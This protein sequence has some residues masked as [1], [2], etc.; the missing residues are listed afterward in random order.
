MAQPVQIPLVNGMTLTPRHVQEPLSSAYAGEGT[1]EMAR[2]RQL[3]SLAE[4]E[5]ASTLVLAAPR[6]SKAQLLSWARRMMCEIY[7]SRKVKSADL[8]QECV[9]LR[10]FLREA[11]SQMFGVS[12]IVD[13]TLSGLSEACLQFPENPDIELFSMWI[14]PCGVP[15]LPVK[16]TAAIPAA[17][18]YG[19][20]VL[21]IFLHTRKLLRNFLVHPFY[22]RSRCRRRRTPAVRVLSA[23]EENFSLYLFSASDAKRVIHLALD[24]FFDF[25]AALRDAAGDALRRRAYDSD[26]ESAVAVLCERSARDG[27][28]PSSSI[29]MPVLH[30]FMKYLYQTVVEFCAATPGR[31]FATAAG[32]LL[33]SSLSLYLDTWEEF[34]E[35]LH[36]E[37]QGCL[38]SRGAV[39][40]MEVS[41]FLTSW[42]SNA[43]T[44][45]DGDSTETPLHIMRKRNNN[46]P[47]GPV[48]PSRRGRSRRSDSV[49]S[50]G[51][52]T[53]PVRHGLFLSGPG[54]R[55]EQEETEGASHAAMC[56]ESQPLHAKGWESPV[57]SRRPTSSPERGSEGDTDGVNGAALEMS[58]PAGAS[59]PRSAVGYGIPGSSP[60]YDA[61]SVGDTSSTGGDLERGRR[62]SSRGLGSRS[63]VS[64]PEFRMFRRSLQM[65]M[66]ETFLTLRE[67]FLGSVDQ[68]LTQM[69]RKLAVARK[70]MDWLLT[71]PATADREIQ[72]VASVAEAAVSSEV[73]RADSCSQ[74]VGPGDVDFGLFF[75]DVE[76]QTP[77]NFILKEVTMDWDV[78]TQTD[79]A[80]VTDRASQS[81]AVEAADAASETDNSTYVILPLAELSSTEGLISTLKNEISSLQAVQRELSEGKTRAESDAYKS[82]EMMNRDRTNFDQTFV[83][84]EM[85]MV[86]L[87]ESF[88]KGIE[89]LGHKLQ[90]TTAT[91]LEHERLLDEEKALRKSAEG[92]LQRHLPGGE[93][94]QSVLDVEL[95][96][97]KLRAA[98]VADIRQILA[99]RMIPIGSSSS[100]SSSSSTS[101]SSSSAATTGASA[102]GSGAPIVGTGPGDSAATSGAPVGGPDAADAALFYTLSFVGSDMKTAGYRSD[103]VRGTRNPTWSQI[104]LSR[105]DDNM[106]QA[107]TFVVRVF[108]SKKGM[109]KKEFLVHEQLANIMSMRPYE[110]ADPSVRDKT[111][112]LLFL[113]GSVVHYC[114]QISSGR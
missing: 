69:Y 1:K 74:P 13:S 110:E 58:D 18:S 10:F 15:F 73:S 83:E 80:A 56:S 75:S 57:A 94:F 88:R 26:I 67:A 48:A 16:S 91:L 59:H 30:L 106:S 52:T 105:M 100:S 99:V 53:L 42:T 92:Q 22:E 102:P 107:S 38:R 112:L 7:N 103:V 98:R 32:H 31:R 82:R 66:E 14:H 108:D 34:I 12:S 109:P 78:D 101:A 85:S 68:K 36:P 93:V 51:T 104:Q 25:C 35:L 39:S 54:G 71:H 9:S 79:E 2:G 44:A 45:V 111:N 49:G 37:I 29:F 8:S 95:R 81:V 6:S 24:P 84:Y 60:S 5:D 113:I 28:I 90:Q 55:D 70:R 63:L 97:Y 27:D 61:V 86:D 33:P 62:R 41:K 20:L 46:T 76:T 11:L 19:I 65:R 23:G 87:R 77:G 47:G 96:R 114:P 40:A 89:Q 64:E 3:R 43:S 72:A 50:T 21:A 4:G 17:K